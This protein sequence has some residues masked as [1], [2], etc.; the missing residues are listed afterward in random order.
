VVQQADYYPFGMRIAS[1]EYENNGN[2]YLYNGKELLDTKLGSFNLDWYDY[3]ARM[4]D[5]ALGRWH[6]IDPL[7]ELIEGISPYNYCFNN[8]VGLDDPSGMM[9]G[10]DFRTNGEAS[11]FIDPTGKIIDVRDDGD[12]NIYLVHNPSE[13]NGSKD[14]LA[15][16]GETP[17]PATLKN[18]KGQNL[19]SYNVANY[20]FNEGD[21]LNKPAELYT[22][23]VKL[24]L[25][26]ELLKNRDERLELLAELTGVKK[27]ILA[28]YLRVLRNGELIQNSSDHGDAIANH[29]AKR[30]LTRS[31]LSLYG[32][33]IVELNDEITNYMYPESGYDAI[34]AEYK[35]KKQEIMN[36]YR[37]KIQELEIVP[38]F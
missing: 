2:N 30:I 19:Y 6:V 12:C 29:A 16:V 7:S 18:H 25:V 38:N 15:V 26:A 5:A 27:E 35:A 13:W 11:T 14:G 33:V 3:G 22:D 9:P 23:F 28:N 21:R 32:G 4:Y 10:I 36:E 24:A 1:S 17:E 37:G 8:P 20:M 34:D 31:L